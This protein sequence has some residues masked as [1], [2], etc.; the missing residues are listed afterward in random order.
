MGLAG[1]LMPLLTAGTS[2]VWVILLLV[3]YGATAIG[4]NGVFL[5]TVAKLV[6]TAYAAM[7]TGG[8]LFFTFFGVVIG[9]PIFGLA[10]SGFGRVGPAFALLALP[11]AGVLWFLARGRWTA[12]LRSAAPA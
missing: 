11:L 5:G 12:T 4:W 2:G 3:T 1:L 8:C 7:A 6:P 9:P 10:A